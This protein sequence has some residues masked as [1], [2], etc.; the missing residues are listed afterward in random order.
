MY[1]DIVTVL[2]KMCETKS[3]RK[4]IFLGMCTCRMKIQKYDAGPDFVETYEDT[5][6]N[7]DIPQIFDNL[8]EL[9]ITRRW[10]IPR[11]LPCVIQVV[12]V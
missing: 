1:C 8:G 10:Q 12:D 7:A 4:F 9:G 6:S 5:V 11:R 2:D 3:A